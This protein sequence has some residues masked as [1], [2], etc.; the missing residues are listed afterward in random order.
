MVWFVI[1]VHQALICVVLEFTVTHKHALN[2]N[3]TSASVVAIN[4]FGVM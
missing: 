3:S 4:F 2:R 1:R